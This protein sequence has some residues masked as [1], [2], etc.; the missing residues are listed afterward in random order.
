MNQV[1]NDVTEAVQTTEF[2]V[3]GA[4]D[5]W[6]ML[7][8]ELVAYILTMFTLSI[9]MQWIKKAA[10]INKSKKEKI[11]LLWIAGMPL[12][13][14]LSL[15]GWH[16]SKGSIHDGYWIVIGL[17]VSTVA[18]GVHRVMTEHIWPMIKA[19][20]KIVADRIYIMTTGKPRTPPQ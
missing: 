8:P 12:G 13:G 15:L 3:K 9:L 5:I 7:P 16:L 10:L 14:V 6:N 4:I 11:R 18:M 19:I 1:N 17:T 20:F 2:I